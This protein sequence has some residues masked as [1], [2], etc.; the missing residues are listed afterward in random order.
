MTEADSAVL[1]HDAA[2][3]SGL[4]P[5]DLAGGQGLP[6]VALSCSMMLL[7]A[8][9]LIARATQAFPLSLDVAVRLVFSAN[10][11]VVRHSKRPA[12]LV[13]YVRRVLPI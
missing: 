5:E 10:R 3:D 13:W 9:A 2:E 12:E 7:S 4:V 1:G 11:T 8:A 6:S